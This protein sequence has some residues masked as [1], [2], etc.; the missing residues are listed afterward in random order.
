MPD[1]PEKVD[2]DIWFADWERGGVLLEEAKH[3]TQWDQTLTLLS[4]E[5]DAI[6]PAKKEELREDEEELGLQEL[7]GDLRWPSKRRRR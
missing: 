1:G 6:P 4:F 7:D 2:A 5:G 3:F